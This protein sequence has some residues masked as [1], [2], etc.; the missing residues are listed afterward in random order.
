MLKEKQIWTK[1]TQTKEKN[2]IRKNKGRNLKR[3]KK[4]ECKTK[5]RILWR[6]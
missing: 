4:N 1:E 5:T 6:K 2:L 3:K